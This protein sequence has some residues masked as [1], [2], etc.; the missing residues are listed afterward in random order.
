MIRLP[1]LAAALALEFAA[2]AKAQAQAQAPD[3]NGR[4]IVTE[5]VYGSALYG[6]LKLTRAG[7]QLAGEFDGDS[8]TGSVTGSALHFTASD[9][10]GDTSV[11]EASFADGRLSGSVVSTDGGD[12]S[13]PQHY[14]FT[15]KRAPA[16]LT[17][18]PRRHEFVP[19]TFYRQF[20]ALTPS[21][22][23]ISPGDTIHTTTVDAGGAD[24]SGV[25]RVLGGNPQTGPFYVRSAMPGDTLAVHVVH[26]KLNR[27]YA[28]SDDRLVNRAMDSRLAARMKDAGKTVRW[29]LDLDKGVAS[30]EAPGPHTSGFAVPVHPM[31][32]CIATAPAPVGGAPPTGDSGGFGGNMDFNEIVEGAT[33]YLPVSVPGALL[34]FGDAHAAQGDGEL[35]GNAL[36]TSMDVEVTV[37]VIPGKRPPSPRVESTS[38]IMAMG[39]GGSLD[40]AIQAAT[41]NMSA[42]LSDTYQLTPTET[43]E[44]LG[45]A[46]EYRISEVADR[47]AGV[48]LKLNKTV[49]AGLKR[50]RE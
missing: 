10:A 44:V 22:L 18:P 43:A 35:T 4:W 11:V 49:L 42:W 2:A 20:S 9:A 46:A 48:V 8:L 13:H 45:A 26:L 47:N 38:Q 29:R 39:F 37:D 1:I 31:L 21:V 16:R 23:T 3:L 40:T 34:Y 17:D 36:E 33:V 15:A 30:P 12:R 25:T 7:A 50:D 27:D 19:T 28:I 5:D 14:S 32:G 41:S 6:S 24:A